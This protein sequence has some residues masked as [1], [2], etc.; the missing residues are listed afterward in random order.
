MNPLK[1]SVTS[2]KSPW[3]CWSR[4]DLWLFGIF[5]SHFDA[6]KNYLWKYYF[7]HC[8]VIHIHDNLW[9]HVDFRALWSDSHSWQPLTSY[10]AFRALWSDP[11][12]WQ[13][14]MSCWFQSIVEWFTLMTTI[15]IICCFQSIVEW[16]TCMTIQPL[17]APAEWR[18]TWLAVPCRMSLSLVPIHRPWH[19]SVIPCHRYVHVVLMCSGIDI[20][21]VHKPCC[22]SVIPCHKYTLCAC[23]LVL[24]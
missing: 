11:H 12:S 24:M 15:D 14:L 22:F 16:F 17:W 5:K 19:F 21:C 3:H 6:G 23:S 2:K 9:C 18:I 13:P 8:G 7:C 4:L 10:V 20:I 1:T